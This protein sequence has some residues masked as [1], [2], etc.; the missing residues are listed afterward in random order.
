MA[1]IWKWTKQQVRKGQYMV[2]GKDPI[3]KIVLEASRDSDERVTDA[4]LMTIAK[5]SANPSY[6]A[7]IRKTLWKRFGRVNEDP[8]CTRKAI[9]IF[10]YLVRYGHEGV[11]TIAQQAPACL[12][13]V[14]QSRVHPYDHSRFYL[15]ESQCRDAAQS[16]LTFLGDQKRVKEARDSGASVRDRI[17]NFRL[18]PDLAEVLSKY[19]PQGG[20]YGGPPPPSSYGGGGTYAGSQRT[21]D[22]HN[23]GGGT[24]S[25][26]QS[27][28]SSS[29]AEASGPRAAPSSGSSSGFQF[30]SSSD[31]EALDFDPRAAAKPS[32]PPQKEAPPSPPASAAPPRGIQQPPAANPGWAQFG[33]QQ[34]AANPGWEQFAQ[35]QQQPQANSGSAQPQQPAADP[36]WAQFGQ[37]QQPAANPGWEQFG[38]QQ[39]QPAANPSWE[40]FGQQQLPPQPSPGWGQQPP[41]QPTV[42]A[43]DLLFGPVPGQ[44]QAPAPPPQPQPQPQPQPPQDRYAG[45]V[46]DLSAPG[47]AQQYQQQAGRQQQ[48]PARQGGMFDEFGDLASIDLSGR[49][50]AAYG[51]PDQ[52]TRGAGPTLG[53]QQGDG[54]PG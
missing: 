25:S 50:R 42:S 20:G 12:S 39:Q 7:S 5:L 24:S 54:R 15:A 17:A 43:D 8:V 4:E 1:K 53:G 22:T 18:D 28:Y 14:A 49:R 30:D 19:V 6:L 26:V 21:A 36:G 47:A 33:Q 3:Q 10:D 45:M 29:P 27:P 9:E 46:F 44:Q 11:L 13:P 35:Q 48:G 31:G 51:R 52:A 2:K 23:S 37:Q 16:L 41:Q 40:Q 34:P 32:P 38:Q